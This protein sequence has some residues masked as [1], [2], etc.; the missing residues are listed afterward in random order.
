MLKPKIILKNFSNKYI[1]QHGLFYINTNFVIEH[2]TLQKLIGGHRQ[3][4][5]SEFL[6]WLTL[7]SSTLVY[8]GPGC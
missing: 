4:F 1:S 8:Y 2:Y 6:L 5:F 7:V 3:G